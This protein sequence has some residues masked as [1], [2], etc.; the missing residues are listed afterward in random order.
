MPKF[1]I[2]V[3]FEVYCVCGNG[4]C[5]STSDI[6]RGGKNKIEVDLCPLCLTEKLREAYDEGYEDGKYH[7]KED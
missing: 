3:D 2:D 7:N 6:S 5:N 1:E 4:L